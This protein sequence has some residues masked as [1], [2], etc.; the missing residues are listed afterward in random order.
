MILQNLL[1]RH[2]GTIDGPPLQKFLMEVR[3]KHLGSDSSEIWTA[4]S[5]ACH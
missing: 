2:V 3:L 1:D 5:P 4:V